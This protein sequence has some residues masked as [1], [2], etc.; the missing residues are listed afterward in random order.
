MYI[1]YAVL[2]I[3]FSFC[4]FMFFYF[5]W[6]IKRRTSAFGLLPEEKIEVSKLNMEINAVTDR[7][8]LLIEDKIKQLKEILDD[9]DKRISVYI[10][11]LEKSRT[12]EVLYSNLG[13][14]I[15]AALKTETEAVNAFPPFSAVRSEPEVKP[16]V[17][18]AV[19]M[20]SE[21]QFVKHKTPSKRQ[22]RA[23]IDLLAN[24]GLS[25]EEIA[26]RLDISMAEVDL[27]MK[28]R[29]RKN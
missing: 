17:T 1:N 22:I 27:A 19:N 5:R 4:L 15:R 13:R 2:L 11:E 7:N 25:S 9:T 10:K 24:D 14:G 26:S 23:S 6:Y 20:Q 28:L 12:G 29:R 8:L 3:C 16:K 21:L 18:P